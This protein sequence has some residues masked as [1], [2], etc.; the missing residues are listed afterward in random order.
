MVGQFNEVYKM[1][2]LITLM[3]RFMGLKYI[4][5]IWFLL[6]TLNYLACR[7]TA[8]HRQATT[9]SSRE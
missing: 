5:F 4:G 7:C 3:Y 2:K 8:V 6:F 9:N 1:A